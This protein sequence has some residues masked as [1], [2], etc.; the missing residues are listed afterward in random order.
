MR[1]MPTGDRRATAVWMHVC[2]LALTLGSLLAQLAGLPDRPQGKRL[3]RELIR[4]P[5]RVVRTGRRLV[6]RLPQALAPA[7]FLLGLYQTLRALGPPG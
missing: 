7:A 3:R 4:V 2:Q 1:H 5:A 6:L